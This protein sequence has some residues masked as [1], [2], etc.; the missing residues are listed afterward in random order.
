MLIKKL[1]NILQTTTKTLSSDYFISY[2]KQ[3]DNLPQPVRTPINT[4][5]YIHSSSLTDL[6]AR[7]AALL[8]DEGKQPKEYVMR[9]YEDS[10]GTR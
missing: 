4:E 2:I 1:G 5:S 3:Q 6:C 8:I 7:N 10:L 9:S